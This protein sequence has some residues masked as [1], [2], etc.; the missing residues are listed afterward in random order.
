M[1]QTNTRLRLMAGVALLALAVGAGGHYLTNSHLAEQR[2]VE[3]QT[4]ERLLRDRFDSTSEQVQQLFTLAYQSIRTISL[5][6]S[7]R[8]IE[9]GNRH[10]EEEDVRASG[11]FSTEG[12][13][14]VQQLYNNLAA[15]VAVSEIYAVVKGFQPDQFPFFM[16]DALILQ[17]GSA[18]DPMADDYNPDFPEESEEE[19][20][21]YYP[22]QIAYFQ[23]LAPR[24][25]FDQ[26]D[27]IPAVASPAM[28]TCDNSQ[29]RSLSRG[30]ER[31]SHGILYSVPF[32]N[33]DGELNGIISAIFRL[34]IFE[35][36]L[37]GVPFVPVDPH[38]Q[39]LAAQQGFELPEQPGNF[40]LVNRQFD[41]YIGDRRNAALIKQVKQLA[42]TQ[43]LPADLYR[44]VLP[45][46][47]SGQW[48]LYYRYDQQAL[49]QAV[50][51][52]Q[53]QLR[54][55]LW[56]GGLIALLILFWL[57]HDYLR[58]QR[59]LRAA[60]H[61]QR[62]ANGELRHS[63]QLKAGAE[64]GL[65]FD[66]LHKMEQQ[67]TEIVAG[68]REGAHIV[69]SGAMEIAAGNQDLASRTQANACALE[70][71]SAT[72]LQLSESAEQVAQHT[73]Q[74][75]ELVAALA[76]TSTQ[77][78]CDIE[79]AAEKMLEIEQHSEQI[80]QITQMIDDIAFKTNLLALNAT[81]EA[82]R[83][84]SAGRGFAVVAN[85]VRNLAT[86]S[87]SAAG[88][89]KQLVADTSNAIDVGGRQVREAAQALGDMDGG[90]AQVHQNI[91][92]IAA[93]SQQQA[94]SLGEVKQAV[95]TLSDATRQNAVLVEQTAV[96]SQ[97]LDDQATVLENQMDYFSL[98]EPSAVMEKH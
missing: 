63:E 89:I 85:E 1:N 28:R 62:I 46:A 80:S 75:A 40:V 86:R 30:D 74:A 69:N 21:R 58:R 37:L 17:E 60:R 42:P 49:A 54:I 47:D 90:I 29:Y 24:F 91:Q 68:A 61:L 5:L 36:L 10:S 73:D 39:R 95:E 81:L 11:R 48:E 51:P 18:G 43:P 52:L 35:S 82:A 15:N 13:A 76:T 4:R 65:L 45:V 56:A 79:R 93:T 14:T 38:E 32:Y 77:S 44:R 66:A 96:A 83:A 2:L 87:A 64:L 57:I 50:A 33:N 23:S 26:I 94:H 78:R 16:Y 71:L 92:G 41:L 98:P 6:P 97:T 9:G 72:V 84:G 88:N 70:Q 12:A 25:V 67:L 34:N 7:I 8:G 53:L 3:Q 59:I 20:Y 22:E 31:D 19:E 55:S 27:Q